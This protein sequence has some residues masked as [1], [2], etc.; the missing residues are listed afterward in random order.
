MSS[1]Y[2]IHIELFVY[3]LYNVQIVENYMRERVK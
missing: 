2:M 1:G 3:M